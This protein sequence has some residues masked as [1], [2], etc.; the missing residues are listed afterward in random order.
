MKVCGQSRLALADAMPLNS[1]RG[2]AG[3]R[4]GLRY[5]A[6]PY[7]PSGSFQLAEERSSYPS[8]QHPWSKPAGIWVGPIGTR[9]TACCLEKLLSR[10]IDLVVY[11]M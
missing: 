11:C 7:L 3:P 4:F 6:A 9:P 1:F 2:K 10:G 5:F 8:A